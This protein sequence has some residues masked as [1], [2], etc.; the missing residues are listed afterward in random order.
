MP[1]EKEA[2]DTYKAEQKQREM[3]REIRKYKRII[4]GTCEEGNLKYAQDKVKALE[5]E[6]RSFLKLHPELRRAHDREKLIV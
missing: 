1:D 2:A 5:K 4:A 3:E 6:L